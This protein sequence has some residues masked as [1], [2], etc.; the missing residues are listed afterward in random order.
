M[1]TRIG[2]VT[3]T[4]EPAVKGAL[5]RVIAVLNR[6][7]VETLIDTVAAGHDPSGR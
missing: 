3:R 4:H 1:F 2:I 6:R 5:E 7:G